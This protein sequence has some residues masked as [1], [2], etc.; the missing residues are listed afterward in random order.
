[1]EAS[2]NTQGENLIESHLS[3]ETSQEDAKWRQRHYPSLNLIQPVFPPGL[4]PRILSKCLLEILV[5][6]K[7]LCYID[8]EH[9]Q[10]LESS[11]VGH[12]PHVAHR[13]RGQELGDQSSRFTRS[14]EFIEIQ[15]FQC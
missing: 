6:V 14:G 15:S 13:K 5:W 2:I 1:M 11:S 9:L 8:N 7:K 3:L 4:L 10:I 12:D